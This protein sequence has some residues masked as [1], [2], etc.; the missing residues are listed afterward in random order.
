MRSP[1]DELLEDLESGKA[2]ARAAWHAFAVIVLLILALA[3]ALHFIARASAQEQR[4]AIDCNDF[5]MQMRLAVWA[6]DM[7]ADENLVAIYHRTV[8]R[9]LG[10][11]LSR[12]IER[13]VRRAWQEKLPATKAVEAAHRRCLDQLGELAV[14][15]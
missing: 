15:G 6:R 4:P 9:H 5:A 10:F 13:E 8:N 12:A 2:P 11:N 14:E 3:M 1:W 7:K